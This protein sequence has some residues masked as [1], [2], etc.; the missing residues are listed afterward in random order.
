MEEDT[1]APL[2]TAG[3]NL[4]QG[5]VVALLYYARAVDNKLL[6]TL[7]A[8]GTHKQQKQKQQ[9]QQSPNSSIML[10][11]IPTTVPSTGPETW[12]SQLTQML[13]STMNLKAAA[14]PVP[15]SSCQKTTPNQSGTVLSSPLQK[16]SFFLCHPQ[17]NHKWLPY[18]KQQRN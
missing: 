4:V 3:V 14:A 10:P 12:S 8:I 13:D 18:I 15:T 2:N 11:H 9:R 1:S 7:N 6:V 17:R 16:S 5:I